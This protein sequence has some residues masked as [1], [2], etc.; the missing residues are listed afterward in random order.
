MPKS[1][2]PSA[3]YCLLTLPGLE[4]IA[5]SEVRRHFPAAEFISFVYAQDEFGGVVF[6]FAE[7]PEKLFQLRTA[8]RLLAVA[9]WQPKVSRGVRDLREISE[10]LAKSGEIGRLFKAMGRL[11]HRHLHTFQVI[12]RKYGKHEYDLRDWSLMVRRAIAGAYPNWQGTTTNPDV[13]VWAFLLGSQA[14]VGVRLPLPRPPAAPYPPTLTAALVLLTEPAAGD[15]FLDPVSAEGGLMLAERLAYGADVT[16]WGARGGLARR[17]Q[18]PDPAIQQVRWQQTH[19]PL[20]SASVDKVATILPAGTQATEQYPLI[21][22][23][24]ARLLR[25]DGLAAVYT[26]EY[27]LLRSKL[28]DLGV[29]QIA[30]GYSVRAGDRWGRIYI[31]QHGSPEQADEMIGE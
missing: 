14:V 3:L 6:R 27:E 5:W 7:A 18:R 10:R 28:R 8:E 11:Q 15:S 16:I 20:D 13:E 17:L 24:V 12:S 30:R 21:L 9:L 23:E 19:L 29:L 31:L 22:S 1:A 25:P 4:S 2:Q 26:E